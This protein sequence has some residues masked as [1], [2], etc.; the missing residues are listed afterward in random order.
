VDSRRVNYDEEDR[1]DD[2][3][4]MASVVA[5]GPRGKS[6]QDSELFKIRYRYA[7]N[8]PKASKSRDFCQ[9]MWA[10]GKVYKKENIVAARKRAVNPGFGEGG[11]TTYDIW[12]YKG[13]PRCQHYWVR[14][15]YLQ[16]DNSQIS[17]NQARR[18][19][20]GLPPEERKAVEIPNNPKEVAQR[21][22][23]MPNC[24]FSPNNPN[25]PIDC[26]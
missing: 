16:E 8:K 2:R 1:M 14:E 13:G 4:N 18:M 9:K 7:G 5:G 6:A 19:I 10:A 20:T 12:F 24:G 22:D 17:V 11:A 3:V 23:D 25:L 15:T 26:K 21:P